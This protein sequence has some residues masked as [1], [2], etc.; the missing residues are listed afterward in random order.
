MF[1]LLLTFV[2]LTVGM[3]SFVVAEETQVDETR[4]TLERIY[5]E[6]EF[7]AKSYS[8][9]W[10][11]DSSGYTRLEDSETVDGGQDIVF[12][13]PATGNK[14]VLVSAELFIPTGKTSPISVESFA[15]S[16]SGNY[17]LVYTNS[18]RVWRRNT[19][20]DYYVLDRGNR[21]LRKLGK[22]FP[23]S[24]LM[25]AKFSPNERH[26]A[27]VHEKNIY[28]EDLVA[29]TTTK[30]TQTSTK[31]IINGTFDWVYEEELSLRDGYRW[32][33]DGNRI[34]YWQLNTEGVR[35]FPLVNNTDSFYPEITWFEYP[36]VGQDNAITRIGV[37]DL[38]T[39][40]TKWLPIKKHPRN[41]YIARM[42]WHENNDDLIL[43]QFNR[44]QN[45][46]QLKLASVSKG[47]E[48]TIVHDRD[49][50]W[51]D[52]CDEVFWF[53][54]GKK[55]TWL[56]ER[57]GWRKA[58]VVD[59]AN[60]DQLQ[61]VTPG[62]FDVIELVKVDNVSKSVYFLASPNNATQRYLYRCNL[63]GSDVKR[64]TP[65]DQSGTH[66]YDVS[67]DG[68]WAIHHF[69]AANQIPKAELVKLPSHETVRT[70]EANDE[71]AE[72]LAKLNE[73]SVEFIK[74]EIEDGVSLDGWRINPPNFDTTKKYP[75]LVYV[76]GEPAGQTVLDRW[77]GRSFLWHRMIAQNGCIVMS[78]DN[79]GTPAPKGRAWRK[80]VYK[81]VGILAPQDQAAAVRA[82][83]EANPQ[84]DESRIGVWGWS[85]GGSM[86][87]NAL[88]KY[89]DL[90]STGISVAPVPNQR[91]YDTIYQ[92]R[93]MG[94]PEENP[95]GYIQGSAINFAKQL[96]GNLLIIHG[97][98]D[99]NCHYQTTEM[100]F[101]ELIRHN[102]PFSMMAYPNRTHAIREGENTSHHLRA[103]MTRYLETH[104]QF[105]PNAN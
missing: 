71:L 24:T 15:W 58:F 56:S 6:Q 21:Q 68:K 93:Y 45:F 4:L 81:Q 63:D 75:L 22:D 17:L 18:V 50:A 52:V 5:G 32:S 59:V 97:T 78:F 19:R 105:G 53:D 90:Y 27:Y 92:E 70:L 41:D 47:T 96:K 62:E 35:Q 60:P 25:F 77:G 33:P 76:Y 28:V 31:H 87:L 66:S 85:G 12:Y 54:D 67:S 82:V 3:A 39:A 36:K 55:F 34:A 38:Q 95:E 73:T 89:P 20:G 2:F 29:D 69:S 44:H 1:R 16:K 49:E 94:L 74:V 86:T 51:I 79:R 91:Y 84:I 40:N 30:L 14:S 80:Y 8:A 46:V 61:P 26:V 57:N 13:D 11:A 64:L 101:N 7:N 43:Q 10:L 23:A 9:T 72:K 98:G 103:L 48:R 83:I 65:S 100:L 42:E 88:F 104:L 99:D 37:V 102:R